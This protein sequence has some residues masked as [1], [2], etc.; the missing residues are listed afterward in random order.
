MLLGWLSSKLGR[1]SPIWLPTQK[2]S[3]IKCSK[4]NCRVP[5]TSTHFFIQLYYNTKKIDKKK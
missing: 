1:G 2:N 4:P 3:K 5:N